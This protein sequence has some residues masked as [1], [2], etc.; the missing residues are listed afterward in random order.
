MK[1]LIK[2]FTVIFSIVAIL[3]ASFVTSAAD[4]FD[5]YTYDSDNKV[6]EAPAAVNIEYSVVGDAIGIGAFSSPQDL[7]IS[8]EGKLYLAD[9]GNNRI[10]VLNEYCGFE[11]E[12]RG[13]DNNG[14]QELF[15]EPE[16]VYF[17]NNKIYICDSG[18]YRIVILDANYALVNIITLLS[19]E[20]LP[21]DFVFKPIKLTVD[22]TDRIFV[23]SEGF[24][25]GLLEFNSNGEYIRYMGA[26]KVSLTPLQ[27]FWRMF[28]TK[29]QREKTTSN[30]SAVYNNV[31]VDEEGFLFVTSSA[32]AYWEYTSGR[33]KPLARLNAKGSDV[34]ARVGNPSGDTDY[35]D[36]KTVRA[37]YTGPSTLVDVCV[38]PYGNYAVL[39]RNRGRVFA[40]T[41]D[42]ELMY[43]FGGPGN[44]NGGMTVPTAVEYYND[45]F[46]ALDS[47]KNQ[48]NVYSLTEYG[49]LFNDVSKAS[50][51]LNYSEEEKLWNDII[52]KNVNCTLAMRGLG[53]AAYRKQDM[54]AA[55]SYYKIARDTEGYS[56]AYVFV[57]REFI[58][59]N[60]I[61]LLVA[62]AAIVVCLVFITKGFKKLVAK[63]GTR[64]FI[65]KLDFAGFVVFHPI[66]G[67]W[68]LKR[69]KRGSVS[70]GLTIFSM[71][72]LVKIAS[73]LATGFLF[74]PK[75]I[76]DYNFFSDLGI[77]LGILLLWSVSQWCV[78]VLMSGEGTFKEILT[79][80]CYSFTPYIWMSAIGLVA[81]RVLSLDEAEL[82][83]VFVAIGIIYTVFLLFMSVVSTH[84][85]TMKKAL[86]VIAIMLVVILLVLFIALILITL[87]QQMVSFVQDLYS[88]IS[89]RI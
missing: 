65:D 76:D 14:T 83:T 82:Y 19:G 86:I 62:F 5:S 22:D 79:A 24:S 46:Y 25:N 56:K 50:L 73:S 11:T 61:L 36:T 1:R 26:S 29:E 60:A 35:P 28:S 20:S 32:F 3:S 63:N 23:V 67:F 59:N 4:S 75:G 38:L 12:I 49:K 42:G 44:V 69:E 84:D 85:Y 2:I 31:E 41:S 88:E 71:A 66:K 6:V 81:S 87:T 37:T 57:R 15:K 10:V 78:T 52:N 80:T 33:A 43:E 21:S 40:Y 58:E 47:G 13:F 30:V 7:F 34:L 8:N 39:D 54:K 72:L 89:F 18:N 70:A 68:E 48:I 74:N 64:S 9:K 53:N 45:K 27:M 17:K 16:G 51:T 55:M 77:M